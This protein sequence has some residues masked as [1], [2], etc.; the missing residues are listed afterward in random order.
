M[1]FR[2][3]IRWSPVLTAFQLFPSPFLHNMLRNK[4]IAKGGGGLL[5]V[6]QDVCRPLLPQQSR[7]VFR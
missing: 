1:T 6:L 7:V 2:V 3:G 4:E 5:P